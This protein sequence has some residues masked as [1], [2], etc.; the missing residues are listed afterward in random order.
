MP[1]PATAMP[2][3]R[4]KDDNMTSN[5]NRYS[6]RLTSCVAISSGSRAPERFEIC[7]MEGLPVPIICSEPVK[8]ILAQIE[9]LNDNDTQVLITG[10]T[11]AGKEL[12]ARAV[13]SMSARRR[14]PFVPFNCAAIN[15]ELAESH[16]FGHRRGSFTGAHGDNRGV[17]RAV[18]DGT[19]FLDEIGEMT[20]DL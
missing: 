4:P 20:S 15:K 10:E 7:E 11:G 8:K 5:S 17:I 16:L 6:I 14:R 3:S 12:F 19:L 1:P 2:G 9:Q 18:E 13:H